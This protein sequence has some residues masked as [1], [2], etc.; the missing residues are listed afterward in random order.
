MHKLSPLALAV[1]GSFFVSPFL[2]AAEEIAKEEQKIEKIQVTGSRI[3]GVDLEGTQPL[4][5]ISADDIKNS[6]ASTVYDLLKDVAQL[7]GGSGTFSTSESGAT[8]TSTPAGQA[9]A[10]LRGLGP[11]ATLTLI[12]GRRVAASSFASGTQN[13]VDINSI[14]LAAIERVEVLA[15]GAS[16]IYGAD[17]VAG[18]INYIL[19][20]DYQ[21]AELNASYGNSTASS[22]EAKYNLNLVF[23][24]ELAGGNLTLFADHFDRNGFM[25][26]DRDATR[27]PLLQSSYSYLP[28][29]APNI[30]YFSAIDG[31]ELATPGCP[32]A[33]VTTEFGEQICAYYPNEDDQLSAPFE[34][35]SAGFIFDTELGNLRWTT[36]FFY[37]QTKS[38][39]QSSPAPINQVDDSEGPFADET[40]L[41]IFPA[42]VRNDILDQIYI[43][44]F[45]TVAGRR[46][47]GFQFD[48]RFA[49]PRTVEIDNKALRLVTALAGDVGNWSWES[50]LTLSRSESEQTAIAGIYN[51][52]KYHAALAGELCNDGSIAS[53]NADTDSL[54]CSGPI[55]NPF[56]NGDAANDALLALAQEMPTRIGESTVYGW[57]AR[58]SGDLGEFNGNTIGSAFGVELRREEITD[59]PSA[60]SQANAANGYLVDVFG[61]GSSLSAADRSQWAA[62]AE[63]YIPL[64]ETLDLQLAGRYDNYNDFG[65]TFNPKVAL[66]W[67][68]VDELVVR[69]SW[70]TSFR[71]PS[72]TQAGVKLRTTTARFDCGA[73][74]AVADLYCEGDGTERSVNVLELG[75]PGLQAEESESVSFGFGWSPTQDT[76][77][78]VDYWQFKHDRL[79]DTDMTAVLNAAITDASLRHCGLVP[80][81][82]QGI[83]YDDALCDVTDAAGN[84][85]EDDGANLTE[86]LGAWID[87]DQPRFNELPLLRDHV[88]LLQN[89]GEQNVSGIDIAFD[90]RFDVAD[91]TLKLFFDATHYV[92][93]ERNRPGSDF[94]EELAGTWRYP[95]NI[96][97]L[98]LSWS[99]EAFFTSLTA[100]YTSAYADDIS[101]L[102]GRELDELDALGV[103]NADGERDV[104]AWTTVRANIGY[105]FANA[106]IS[107]NVDN[108]FDRDPPRAYGSSRGFDSINH[109]ALGR[110]YRLL[111]S[112]RF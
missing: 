15:T 20:K 74:Q 73:N 59:T 92:S 106:S 64:T 85:I 47:Y 39:S 5:I 36:D 105:D 19:K 93:F 45:D 26:K 48:A 67:R 6:G 112:Y 49:T 46:L 76:T 108:L 90:Q 110:N 16:A 27:S 37:S 52:Y 51:R 42:D 80:D 62:F 17:A 24:T 75:N 61:F 87:Y 100:Y 29:T 58:I 9:A 57:D 111:F 22:D 70:A 88:I 107:L 78:T 83:S 55:Y 69:A 11:A 8:S 53:Y 18:V 31:N 98:G 21:G 33:L 35:S 97:S 44:P 34:S 56:L 38:T 25:A 101:G 60:N 40:V 71:A 41:D 72:L 30:Y 7:R 65:S 81:G 66:S 96:A 91:G 3:K 82:A 50:A 1:A 68:P 4:V 43:D 2:F 84:T 28:K 54:S 79:V 109:D 95:E 99:G 12:N 89:T 104:A 77:L 32:S 14:P 13:F 10:S 102:R 63:F 23:G 86:I 103:L 94:I